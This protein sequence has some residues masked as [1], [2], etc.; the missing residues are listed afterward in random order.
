[1]KTIKTNKKLLK[2]SMVTATFIASVVGAS[3]MATPATAF[4]NA[5]GDGH[6]KQGCYW[7]FPAL[8]KLF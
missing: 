5:N 2:S 1:M 8:C 6:P 3:F 7:Y 4:A